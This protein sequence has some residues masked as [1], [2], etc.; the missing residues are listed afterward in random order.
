MTRMIESL[1]LADAKCM[2]EAAER[3]ADQIGIAYNA[4]V[5]D[6]GG[7]LVAF[8]RQ[9][10]ALIG[11]IDIAINKACTAR[12]F[13]TST[14]SLAALAQPNAP[15]YGIQNADRENIVIFGGGI[16]VIRNDKVI[17]AVGASAGTVQQDVAI[18][19]AAVAAVSIPIRKN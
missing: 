3:K 16:P 18:A 9:D 4:A 5:V 17:G 12:L 7:H 19:E 1:S 2:L 15:L 13:D 11:S 10:G 14:E 8:F 6:A